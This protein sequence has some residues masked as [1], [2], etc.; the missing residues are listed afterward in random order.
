MPS[1]LG[2]DWMGLSDIA[3]LYDATQQH[4]S[5]TL[6]PDANQGS[7]NFDTALVNELTLLG[8]MPQ[9]SEATYQAAL[10]GIDLL[11][12]YTTPELMGD[13]I[14]TLS[15]F[16][17]AN[18]VVDASSM[19]ISDNLVRALVD[20]GMLEALTS[21]NLSIDV[22][23]S[24]LNQSSHLYTTL[25]TMADLGVDKVHVNDGVSQIYIDLG[26]PTDDPN[27]INDIRA[28]LETL[29]P[30][31][32]AKLVQGDLSSQDFTLVISSGLANT[33]KNTNTEGNGFTQADLDAMTKLGISNFAILDPD[34]TSNITQ[35]DIFGNQPV[36]QTPLTKLP[37]VQII[38]SHDPILD[39]LMH[40]I[41][42][43]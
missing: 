22:S 24:F 23:H 4:S 41:K 21:S 43:V 40:D 37:D 39:H 2:Q 34:N 42:P 7:V 26:L 32:G 16:G 27:A 11:S 10:K 3:S 30:A 13:L 35:N 12:K 18:F 15:N 8:K 5:V 38:G 14:N 19:Q 6:H 36:A 17:V 20:A 31:N 1:Y 25:K 28:L 29:D 33:I 9:F